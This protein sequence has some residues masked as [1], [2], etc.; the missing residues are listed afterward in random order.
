[1]K[2]CNTCKISKL[3][4]FF[5][6]DKRNK[7]G[8]QGSC[9][10]CRRLAKSKRRNEV[11]AGINLTILDDQICVK[12]HTH[13]NIFE[14]YRDSGFSSG[15]SSKCKIC[16]DGETKQWRD[17]KR[18]MYNAYMLQYRKAHPELYNQRR[19]RSLKHLYGIDQSQYDVLFLKQEGKCGICE[20]HQENFDRPLS[21]DHDHNTNEIRGLLCTGCN[22]KIAIFDNSLELTAAQKYLKK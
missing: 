12:C 2:I 18:P 19:N 1:M 11:K 3:E 5:G 6:V 22:V 20:K 7:S 15:F 16:K 14:F 21:V 17:Q 9:E 4:S 10:E 13:K 8:L